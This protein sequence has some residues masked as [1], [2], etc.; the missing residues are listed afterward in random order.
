MALLKRV[1]GFKVSLNR[2]GV[3][4]EEKKHRGKLWVN[5]LPACAHVHINPL[6]GT[7][8]RVTGPEAEKVLLTQSVGPPRADRR[9]DRPLLPLNH[10]GSGG[11]L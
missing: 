11:L 8:A 5:P 3:R 9:P 4:G 2:K 7:K 10:C 1:C 6:E